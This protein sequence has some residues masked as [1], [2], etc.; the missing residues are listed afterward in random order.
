MIEELTTG[1]L[2]ILIF[3][4][5]F[6]CV[7]EGIAQSQPSQLKNADCVALNDSILLIANKDP[8]NF[9]RSFKNDDGCLLAVVELMAT[10]SISTH[11]D[12]YLRSLDSVCKASDGFLAEGMGGIVLA[13]FEKDPLSY[14]RFF[15]K[16]MERPCL[17]SSMIDELS[18]R[19][20]SNTE[21]E[22]KQSI[23]EFRNR[24]NETL[25]SQ[26]GKKKYFRFLN[27]EV[28][29]KIDAEKY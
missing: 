13:S 23:A 14:I 26:T 10:Q 6:N 27:E 11:D 12:K 28:V 3:L 8:K 9:I 5:C 16:T 2:R 22:R 20:S 17:Y 19:T 18:M 25:R 7:T 15:L 21:E 24:L 1:T 4:S 29:A